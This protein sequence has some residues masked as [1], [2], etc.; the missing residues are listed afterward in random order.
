MC[1]RILMFSSNPGRIAAEIKVD[2]PQPRSR[3]DPA[4]RELVDDIYADASTASVRCGE[5]TFPARASAWRCHMFRPTYC[6]PDGERCGAN[7]MTA[8]P[9]CRI[10]PEPAD[11]GRRPVSDR[12][13]AA[14]LAL[15]RAR[16]GRSAPH[17]SRPRFADGEVDERKR[18]FAEHLVTYVPLAG[19]IKHVLDERPEH[20]APASRFR[21]ELEDYMSPRG[22]RETLARR[23]SPGAA[24]ARSLPMTTSGH[25][26]PGK[27]GLSGD[28]R[29][30]TGVRHVAPAYAMGFPTGSATSPTYSLTRSSASKAMIPNIRHPSRHG[31]RREQGASATPVFRQPAF[32]LAAKQFAQPLFHFLTV[33]RPEPQFLIEELVPGHLWKVVKRK[34][35]KPTHPRRLDRCFQQG[36]TDARVLPIAPHGR[37]PDVQLVVLDFRAQEGDGPVIRVDGHKTRALRDQLAVALDGLIV[38]IR[39]PGQVRDLTDGNR[40]TARWPAMPAHHRPGQVEWSS[41]AGSFGAAPHGGAIISPGRP[42]AA[43]HEPPQPASE[44]RVAQ[45]APFHRGSGD[46]RHAEPGRWRA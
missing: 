8:G 11:G 35:E 43:L 23:R 13:D 19:H 4:F 24:T 21:E 46:H 26:Q 30:G 33:E 10:S 14:A 7:P 40:P 17:P 45:H 34:S 12:R 36:A 29:R 16:G 9:I 42:G 3:L 20:H 37:L 44:L 38:P 27:P 18:L 5:G 41:W 31:L 25:V 2:L 6:R 28:R 1:D 32:D 39:D 22:R 15:R